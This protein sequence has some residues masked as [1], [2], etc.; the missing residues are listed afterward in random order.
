MSVNA[1]GS[2]RMCCKLMT[3]KDHPV[4]KRDGQ[5]CE[6]CDK[7][8][9]CTIYETRP[10]TCRAFKCAWLE[11]QELGPDGALPLELRPDKSKV[12]FAASTD[13]YVIMAYVDPGFKGAWQAHNVMA[14][15]NVFLNR[16]VR[17]CVSQEESTTKIVLYK[18]KNGVIH[19][20]MRKFTE[21]DENGIQWTIP[22]E[23]L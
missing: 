12:I 14:L 10:E 11:S 22:Q 6:F 4:D 16:R 15:I 1:C 18:D 2:C 8:K 7:A 23:G 17:V 9:G 3:V 20:G 13:P 5:W 19:R 21:P